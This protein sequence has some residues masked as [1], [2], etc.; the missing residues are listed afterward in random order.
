MEKSGQGR[1]G[2]R[3]SRQKNPQ[4]FDH[5]KLAFGGTDWWLVVK[6]ACST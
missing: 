1:G 4:H 5:A 2:W 3:H 6:F